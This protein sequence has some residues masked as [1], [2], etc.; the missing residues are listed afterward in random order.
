VTSTPVEPET[1]EDVGVGVAVRPRQRLELVVHVLV[2][3]LGEER[4]EQRNPA[5]EGG[6][7]VL[8]VDGGVEP[9]VVLPA[10]EDAD[11]R[12]QARREL[13]PIRG[14]LD[15]VDVTRRRAPTPPPK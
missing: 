6:S 9:L 4:A 7:P 3:G 12:G 1:G 11:T 10:I 14:G 2:L 15:V 5:E 8:R 13:V